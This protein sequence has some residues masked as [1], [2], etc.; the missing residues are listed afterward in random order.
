MNLKT[1]AYI[2]S[3]YGRDFY[4][5]KDANDNEMTLDQWAEKYPGTNGLGLVAI[6]NMRRKLVGGGVHF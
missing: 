4:K 3:T 5:I 1:L 6:R 2:A